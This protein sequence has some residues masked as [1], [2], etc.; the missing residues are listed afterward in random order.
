LQTLPLRRGPRSISRPCLGQ[1]SDCSDNPHPD[2]PYPEPDDFDTFNNE[3]ATVIPKP[4][5]LFS[6][7][8]TVDR[9]ISFDYGEG[10]EVNMQFNSCVAD[11]HF[12][13][14]GP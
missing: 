7:D 11:R 13:V 3:T 10:T 14:H 5:Y 9:Q 6:Y 8:G 4:T 12:F 1:S 2:H